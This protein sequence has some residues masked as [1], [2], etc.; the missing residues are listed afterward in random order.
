[1]QYTE[2]T[3]TTSNYTIVIRRPILTDSER[4]KREQDVVKAL[5][6]FAKEKDYEKV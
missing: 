3:I 5:E 6:R 2:K 1:M 4:Q